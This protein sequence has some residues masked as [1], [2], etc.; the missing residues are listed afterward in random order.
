M[1]LEKD[2]NSKGLFPKGW[3]MCSKSLCIL[4]CRKVI[5]R[6]KYRF[7]IRNEALLGY[8]NQCLH[9]YSYWS[10]LTKAKHTLTE[11]GH[12]HSVMVFPIHHMY[13]HKPGTL[14]LTHTEEPCVSPFSSFFFLLEKVRGLSLAG[15][16]VRGA[17]SSKSKSS[18]S[19][20]APLPPLG[21]AGNATFLLFE[22][23]VK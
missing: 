18:S 17:R 21:A 22:A 19:K 13:G 8:Q 5:I 9:W 14:G 2:E 1:G 12:L 20:P 6:S 7:A 4:D 10:T 16:D 23:A 11:Y 15:G 3:I